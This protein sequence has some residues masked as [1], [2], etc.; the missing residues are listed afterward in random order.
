MSTAK[1]DPKCR[2]PVEG[3]PGI[4]GIPGIPGLTV[5]RKGSV[6]LAIRTRPLEQANRMQVAEAY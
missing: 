2:R 6:L 4:P 3:R 5:V 1:A